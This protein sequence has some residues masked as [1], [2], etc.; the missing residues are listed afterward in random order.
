MKYTSKPTILTVGSL[1]S[2]L[3]VNKYNNEKI[4]ILFC[5]NKL[6]N[7]KINTFMTMYINIIL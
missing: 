6:F 3:M 4:S 2:S 1:K 7:I 5:Q